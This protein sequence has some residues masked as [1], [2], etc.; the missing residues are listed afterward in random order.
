VSDLNDY[1]TLIVALRNAVDYNR[2]R[3][4]YRAIDGTIKW[5]CPVG[6]VISDWF[7]NAERLVRSRDL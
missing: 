6:D 4:Y 5:G 2:C 1:I 3:Q 7:I